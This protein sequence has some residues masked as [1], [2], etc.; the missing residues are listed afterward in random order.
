MTDDNSQRKAKGGVQAASGIR[1]SPL[2]GHSNHAR[3]AICSQQQ[4]SRP[5]PT[6]AGAWRQSSR[7]PSS[8]SWSRAFCSNRRSLL[9]RLHNPHLDLSLPATPATIGELIATTC[10]KNSGRHEKAAWLWSRR[11]PISQRAARR[12]ARR[13]PQPPITQIP[14]RKTRAG[15]SYRDTSSRFT[16]SPLMDG[17]YLSD[18]RPSG[19]TEPGCVHHDRR[20]WLVEA[21]RFGS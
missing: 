2:D 4:G 6:R 13:V 16:R 5:P 21:R 18:L 7:R 14:N 8:L 15:V 19:N 11:R 9:G 3:V 1:M 12:L 10:S 17:S 20:W